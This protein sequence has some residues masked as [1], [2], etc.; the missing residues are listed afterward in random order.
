MSVNFDPIWPWS[1]LD[2]A[3]MGTGVMGQFLFVLLIA[4][5]VLLPLIVIVLSLGSYVIG[6]QNAWRRTAAIMLLRL[7]ACV[8]VFIAVLRP[9]LGF[10][11]PA[12]KRGVMLVA[13]DAS[14]S[15]S[16]LDELDNQSRW[17]YLQR[18]LKDNAPALK[19]LA[20]E[21]KIDV[22]FYRFAGDAAEAKV[23]ELGKPD[24]K[25]TDF[26]TML[27]TIYD[28]RNGQQPLLGLLVFSDGA[29]NGTKIPALTEAGRWRK[30]PCPIHAFGLGKPTTSDRQ[31]DI[32]VA[33]I[34]TS[35]SPQVPV[36]AQLSAKVIVHAP[37]FENRKVRVRMFL[38]DKEVQAQDM[39]LP[40]TINNEVEIKC[41]APAKA[42]EVK[43][44][45][46]I[47]PL[48]GEVNPNNNSIDTYVTVTQE[49]ISVL[50]VDKARVWEPQ[51][52]CDAL[53]EE[54]R[55]RLYP[56]WLRGNVPANEKGDGLFQFDKQQ[57]DVIIF[58]DVTA[59]QMRAGNP[60]ALT[61]IK[62]LVEKGSGFMM[63]GGYRTFGNGDWKGTVIA[64]LL[65][66]ELDVQGQ[67]DNATQMVPTPDGLSEF[68]YFMQLTEKKDD[69]KLAWSRL[70][71]MVG[72][73]VL[74]KPKPGVAKVVAETTAGKPLLV[75]GKY[76]EGRTLALGGDTTHKWIRNPETKAMHHQFWRRLVIW[77]ARQDEMEGSVRVVPDTRRLPLHNDLGFRVEMRSKGNVP[78]ENG[79]YKVEVFGP[80]DL[81]KTVTT[82]RKEKVNRGTFVN[83]DV[84]GEYR[85]EVS[86]E[87]KDPNGET[88]RDKASA[89]FMVYDDDL[90]MTRRAADHEFLKK[91]SAAGGGEFHLAKD[92]GPFLQQFQKQPMDK[93]RSPAQQ[94]PN[95]RT[96]KL[97]PFFVLFFL[98]FV[99]VLS[100]EWL[101]RRRWGMV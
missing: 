31:Q 3:Q 55:I 9:S 66:V 57:Y 27:R 39:V 43:V 99:A 34:I 38:D 79:E 59:E 22:V 19:K 14:E 63:L 94:W 26:G 41:T 65:P 5:L 77:L 21:K 28:A 74:G 11:D 49:G 36:K 1:K 7:G 53:A 95:W 56:V 73:T 97:S 51:M 54:S 61:E 64:D 100:G 50:L 12:D 15:M 40:L 75:A 89:R 90:E 62:R 84:P 80:N 29:D 13:I 85:I 30:H 35:P 4:L 10:D 96:T 48:Q 92:L 67:S 86:G 42:G 47:D 68:K 2:A 88:V 60:N 82:V 46:K 32:A 81:R 58:G 70:H 25:R 69:A 98:I 83:T 37:G 72:T 16:I 101:L 52:I 87:G 44:T 91:L 23:D 20:D 71:E 18:V 6:T 8:L 33:D 24:G 76:G 17:D 78:I 93:K 45:V